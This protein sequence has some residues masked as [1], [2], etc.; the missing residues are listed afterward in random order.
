MSW[1]IGAKGCNRCGGD[2]SLER[3]EYGVCLACLQCGAIRGELCPIGPDGIY[4]PGAVAGRGVGRMSLIQ[5]P[6]RDGEEG[7]HFAL[8]GY[9]SIAPVTWSSKLSSQRMREKDSDGQ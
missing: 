1:I 9:K 8:S 7:E 4:H 6:W 2:L 3:D 5:E